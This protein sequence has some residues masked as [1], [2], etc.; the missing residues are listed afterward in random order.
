MKPNRHTPPVVKK[1]SGSTV[2]R[3]L[4]LLFKFYP[5]L[6]PLTVFCIIFAAVTSSIP[7]LFMQNVFESI[8]KYVASGDWSLAAKEIVPTI[9]LLASH[10]NNRIRNT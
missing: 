7:S 2:K 1:I 5:V 8:E 3:V 9:I 10:R 6:F 4:G